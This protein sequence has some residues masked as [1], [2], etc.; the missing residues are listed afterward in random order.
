VKEELNPVAGGIAVIAILAIMIILLAVLALVVVKALAESS[1]G[2][3]TVGATIPIAMLMGGYLRFW[4]VG[5]VLEASAF[6]VLCF[7]SRFGAENLSMVMLH[8][9]ALLLSKQNRSPGWFSFT[10]LPPA[11]C[12]CGCCSRPAIT[13]ALS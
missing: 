4:R 2:V 3:F 12:R 1:W 9:R 7:S 13:S 8:G 6:G 10:V 11:S 5:K